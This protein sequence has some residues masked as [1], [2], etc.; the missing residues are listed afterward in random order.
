MQAAILNRIFK[1]GA[2]LVFAS[3]LRGQAPQQPPASKSVPDLTGI[4]V[5]RPIPPPP[6]LPKPDPTAGRGAGNPDSYGFTPNIPEMTPWAEEK[7]K[8]VRAGTKDPYEMKPEAPDSELYP[9][10]LPG[11]FPRLFTVPFP[12]RIVQTPDIIIML[13][14]YESAVRQIYMDGRKHVSGAPP[15]YMGDSIGHWEGDTLVV[16][17]VNIDDV[18]W[19]D[20]L[21]HPHSDVLR[22]TERIQR[23]DHNTLQIDFT[24]ED[25][26]AYTKPWTGKKTF[27]LMPADTAMGEFFVCDDYFKRT[28]SDD[29][30]GGKM[31][32]RP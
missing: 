22:V 23:P 25:P 27:R 24:F 3:I 31:R 17:T 20:N 16:D 15:T 19:I 4:W 32:G 26:K 7:Y 9:Y 5:R 12:I 30:K 1:G 14:E 28:Y 2:V 13:S 21:G 8:L 18:S 11:G 6:G 10:C 29:L